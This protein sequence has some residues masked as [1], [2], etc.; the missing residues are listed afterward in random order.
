MA[1]WLMKTADDEYFEWDT[2]V[3]DIASGPMTHEEATDEHGEE[4]VRFTDEHLCSCRA[5]LG[6]RVVRRNGQIVTVGNGEL[7]FHQDSYEETRQFMVDAARIHGMQTWE[8]LRL[9]RLDD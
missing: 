5:R 1:L 2:E 3:D 9:G 7:A 8:E 6:D 4:R